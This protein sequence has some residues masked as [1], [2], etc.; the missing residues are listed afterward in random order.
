M[1]F[2]PPSPGNWAPTEE[3]AAP[4]FL[5]RTRHRR[6][7]GLSRPYGSCVL[8]CARTTSDLPSAHAEGSSSI[9]YSGLVALGTAALGSAAL[10]PGRRGRRSIRDRAAREKAPARGW[11]Q[12]TRA[13][14]SL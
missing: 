7:R 10:C 8:G 2:S 3:L 12:R 1:P 5:D 14:G 13:A 6:Q 11:G 4:S 9:A